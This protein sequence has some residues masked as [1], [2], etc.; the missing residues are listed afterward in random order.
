MGEREDIAE[1]LVDSDA[2][3][4]A[5][6]A[7][8]LHIKFAS[9]TY[10][11]QTYAKRWM[12]HYAAQGLMVHDPTVQWGLQNIGRVPWYDLQD[13]DSQGVLNQAKNFG[14][15]SGFVVS[16]FKADSK[17]IASF[18][19][20]DRE[21]SEAEMDHLQALLDDL[22]MST[23]DASALTERDQQALTDLSNR[24]TH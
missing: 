2:G 16:V 19:R 21:F 20:A 6:F 10:L 4:P 5:G 23:L 7:I 22:H 13:I 11:F 24:L 12:D 8:A 3:S 14:L 15:M 9:P 1:L 18:A 17:S